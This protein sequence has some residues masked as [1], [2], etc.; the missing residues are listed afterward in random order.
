MSTKLYVRFIAS[1]LYIVKKDGSISSPI[2]GIT[3]GLGSSAVIQRTAN[4]PRHV[5]SINVSF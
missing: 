3:T 4:E 5:I 1:T 2:V